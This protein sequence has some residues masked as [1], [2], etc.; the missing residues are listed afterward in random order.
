M[1]LVKLGVKKS[2]AWEWANTR[3]GYWHIAKNFILNT[4]STKERLRQA[5]YLFLS[6]HYQKV[7]IKT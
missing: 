7:M 3:K 1:N 4:T 5:G 6:E 2:K